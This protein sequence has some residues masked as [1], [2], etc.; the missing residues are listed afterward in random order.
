M[1]GEV[2]D[3]HAAVARKLLEDGAEPIRRAHCTHST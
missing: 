3:A 1:V 2:R